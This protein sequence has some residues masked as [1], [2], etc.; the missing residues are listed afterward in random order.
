MEEY[1]GQVAKMLHDREERLDRPSDGKSLL[2][3]LAGEMGELINAHKHDSLWHRSEGGTPL[4]DTYEL[5][6]TRDELGD[7]LWYL[8]AFCVAEG[9]DIEDV[10]Q[11]N[12]KKLNERYGEVK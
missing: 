9:I 1:V 12:L 8:V 11:A 2:L 3:E 6:Q 7:V 4:S 5:P 10:M